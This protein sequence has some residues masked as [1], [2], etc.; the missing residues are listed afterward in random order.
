[1]IFHAPPALAQNYKFDYP[2]SFEEIRIPTSGNVSLHGLLFH[3]EK[4]AKGLVFYLHGNGGSL[5]GWGYMSDVYTKLGYDLFILDYR[6]YGKSGGE[7][8]DMQE[9]LDDIRTAYNKMKTRYRDEKIIVAGFSIGT[10]P[11]AWLSSVEHPRMLILQAPYYDLAAVA[12]KRFPMVP[13]SLLRYNFTTSA[14]LKNVDCPVFMFHGTA[15]RVVAFDNS[16][17]IKSENPNVNFF[18]IE[19]LG[20]IRF[21]DDPEFQ[22]HLEAILK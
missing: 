13:M 20:H 11:A 6:S 18:P 12:G 10:G 8:T 16:P 5:E 1:M 3:T 21:N 9:F 7:I 2:A 22:R 17:R 14:Y 4:P 15:D 19:G